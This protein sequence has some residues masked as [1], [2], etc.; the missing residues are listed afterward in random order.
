MKNSFFVI[1][2]IFIF[3]KVYSQPDYIEIENN[4]IINIAN[5]MHISD[6]ELRSLYLTYLYFIDKNLLLKSYKEELADLPA[7]AKK[8]Y[9]SGDISNQKMNLLLL[10]FHSLENK[11]II[12]S[13]DISIIENKI[14]RLLKSASNIYPMDDSLMIY[15]SSFLNGKIE[16]HLK[17][18]NIPDSIFNSFIEEENL[19]LEYL[20]YKEELEFYKIYQLPY[21][22]VLRTNLDQELMMDEIDKIEYLL[23][24]NE[25]YSTKEDYLTLINNYNQ[26]ALETEKYYEKK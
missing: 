11:I 24:I 17:T 22:S 12:N 9:N 5:K 3:P 15:E 16:N 13:Y 2:F 18:E 1:I 10:N 19:I 8:A 26:K 7:Y 20:K 21:I 4:R 25:I 6:T 14:K 23:K